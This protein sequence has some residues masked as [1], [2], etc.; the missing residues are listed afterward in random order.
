[1]QLDLGDIAGLIAAVAFL[2]LVVFLAVPLVKL[3]G[4]L[5]ETRAGIRDAVDSLTPTL[6]ETQV[7]VREAN[8]QLAKV[9]GITTQVSE[10]T[11]N[12]SSLVALTASTI[13]SP[14][15]KIAGAVAGIGAGVSAFFG[16]RRRSK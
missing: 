1:M 8:K 11:D 5:D 7:T 10:T 13:G 14:L 4:V 16:T 6:S 2:A 3:G 9:D 12:V 15:I